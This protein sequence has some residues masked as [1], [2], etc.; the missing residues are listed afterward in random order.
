[1]QKLVTIGHFLNSFDIRFNLFKDMLEEA[2]IG[3]IVVNENARIV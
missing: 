2:G 3:Y 1:M